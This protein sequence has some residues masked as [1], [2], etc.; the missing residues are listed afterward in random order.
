MERAR[1]NFLHGRGRTFA[2]HTFYITI[3]AL[4]A[5]KHNDSVAF[6][7]AKSE[8]PAYMVSQTVVVDKRTPRGPRHCETKLCGRVEICVILETTQRLAILHNLASQCQ[9]LL[10]RERA[11]VRDRRMAGWHKC[12]TVSARETGIANYYGPR[13][14]K[15]GRIMR[16]Q[17]K[18]SAAAGHF[19][20]PLKITKLGPDSID[21]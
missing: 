10:M 5:K 7:E 15:L 1:L 2:L 8:P 21:F 17:G 9:S 16:S 11:C 6:V 3:I 13:A 4:F 12:G 18:G 20:Q 14:K 19:S